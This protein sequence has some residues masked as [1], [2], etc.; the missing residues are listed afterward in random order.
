MYI[1]KY[2][3]LLLRSF[4]NSDHTLEQ[5]HQCEEEGDAFAHWF[6]FCVTWSIAQFLDVLDADSLG[7]SLSLSLSLSWWLIF[8]NDGSKEVDI[9]WFVSESI[10]GN[11]PARKHSWRPDPQ[12]TMVAQSRC[13]QAVAK[14]QGMYDAVEQITTEPRKKTAKQKKKS[15]LIEPSGFYTLEGRNALWNRCCLVAAAEDVD[16]ANGDEGIC[17]V[18]V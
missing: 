4:L 14:Q 10:M 8:P 11:R 12:R 5:S 13:R 1:L 7:L 3:L 6:I 2:F 18:A 15:V 16:G 17:G 9:Q